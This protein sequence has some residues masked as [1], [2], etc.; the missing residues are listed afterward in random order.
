VSKRSPEDQDVMLETI[1]RNGVN[2][3]VWEESFVE[4]LRTQ[5]SAGRDLSE[6]QLQML[7]RIYAERTP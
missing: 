6:K 7:E 1:E 5:R 2:L 4:S 3:T